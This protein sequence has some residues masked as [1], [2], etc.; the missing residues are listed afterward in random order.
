MIEKL[1]HIKERG[2]SIRTEVIAGLVTFF[3]MAYII[4]VN[5][6][7]LSQTGMDFNA[8]MIATAVAAAVGCFLTAF[9]ANMPFAQASGM[10]L[11]TFFTYSICFGMGYTWQQGLT[12]VFLSGLIFLAITLTPARKA[13]IDSIPQ[14]LKSAISVGIGLFITFIGLINAGIVIGFGEG[15]GVYTD[16][17]AITSGAPLVAI[18]GILITAILFA[19]KVKGA[20]LIGIIVTT[21]IGIPFGV[22]VIPDTLTLSASIAPVAF[23]LDFSVFSLG[24]VPVLTAILTFSM[25]DMFDTCGT[26]IGVTE[27]TNLKN[28]NTDRVLLADALATCC[29]ALLGTTTVTTFV[30]SSTGV[31]EGG[32]TGL[33]NV[34]TGILFLLSC[35]FAPIV[36]IVP[37]AATAPALILVGVFMMKNAFNI[38]W[39]NMEEA[40]PAFLTIVMMPFAYSISDG[41]AFGFISYIIMKLVKGKVKEISI[42]LWIISAL[43]LVLY[44]VG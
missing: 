19:L 16:L 12:I 23:K 5:P 13:I 31:E 42:P 17:G 7:Y 10:G 30:E 39:S 41:I 4:F 32:R 20:M 22:T 38:E 37:S 40:I 9:I 1:F 25:V 27:N 36:G 44:I 33:A 3:A 35:L 43:F 14:T 24:L 21:L 28:E 2:S 29:G 15:V 6:S 11:N 18:I 26:L 8:V 34:V